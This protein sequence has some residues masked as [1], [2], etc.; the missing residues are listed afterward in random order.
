MNRAIGVI[1]S[2]VGGLTVAHELMRQLPKEKL[3][4][5]GDTAR[6][7]YGPRTEQEVKQFTWEMVSYLLEKNIKMLVIACNTATAFTLKDLQERLDI[8]VIGVIK[9]G[10]R[11]A[12]KFTRN[13]QVGVIGTEGTIRSKAYSNALRKIKAKL[14][15][16]PLACPLFVPM[17]EKGILSG[18]H[19][20]EVVEETLQPLIGN[21]MDTLILG[22]THYPLLKDTIQEVVGDGV[23]VI[24][25]SEETARETSTILEV[26]DLLYNGDRNPTH[27]FY[28]TG[29]LKTFKKIANSI[30]KE[31]NDSFYE[32][33]KVSITENQ[34]A[35]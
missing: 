16:Y 22:C 18:S 10:A 1:D 5:L 14:Q 33:E 35:S 29:E 8:P 25:S 15:V 20:K 17:V 11:A 9:P 32:I 7:P 19:A 21:G 6:C 24:S 13:D 4:Y 27:Q 23:T 34:D 2:G 3:I 28:A 12:I 26:H 30:F 31:G